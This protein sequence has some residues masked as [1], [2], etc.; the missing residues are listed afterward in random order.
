MVKIKVNDLCPCGS[1][2][3][4]KK[5]CKGKDIIWGQDDASDFYRVIPI[6]GKLEELVGQLDE[7]IYK[8]FERE[9]LPDDPLM[10]HT[11]M[12]SNKDHERKMVEAMEKVGTNPAF[13]YA[14]KKTG[15]LVVE[16]MVERTPGSLVDEW[17]RAVDEYYDFGGDPDEDSENNQ[18]ESKLNVLVEDIDSLIYLFG[19]FVNKYFNEDYPDD[20]SPD[21]AE[22]LSPVAYMGL[23]LAKSQRA[24]RSIKN[25]ILEEY[26]EDALKLVRGIYENYLHIVLVKHKP[27]SIIS[28]VDAKCGLRDGSFKYLEKNGKQDKRKVVRCADGTIYPTSI[29]GYK[30]AESSSRG[31]D[32]EFYDLFYDRAS[33]VVHPSVFNIRD[34]VREGKLSPLDSDWKEEA[35]IYSVFVGCLISFE[36]S[37]IENLPTS[38][39]GDCATVV[40]KL[41]SN[42]IE[43]LEFLRIW[44]DRIEVELPELEVVYNRSN[45][46]LLS[47]GENS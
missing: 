45:E 7:E 20:S 31:F 15:M 28:L 26:N 40:R 10:P 33:D 35:V 43:T 37:S 19:I 46:I 32:V 27:E 30:M 6:E 3:K 41:L 17:D 13:I 38:L 47:L 4:Y 16:E 1:G 5:C 42:L 21:G 25:L 22:I 12:F 18:F 9:R 29:S 23:N 14:Y 34:Y 44:S 24:L 8:H 36:V 2:R 39:R 11:L